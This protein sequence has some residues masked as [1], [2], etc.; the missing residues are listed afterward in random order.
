MI[1]VSST[2]PIDRRNW[3]ATIGLALLFAVLVLVPVGAVRAQS[4]DSIVWDRY[5]VTLDVQSDGTVQV[6]EY[7]EITFYGEYSQGFAY[8]P[9]TQIEDIEDVTVSVANQVGD[10]PQPLE[11]VR[12]SLYDADTGTYTYGIMSGELAI[13]YAF[14]PTSWSGSTTRVVVLEYVV[15]ANQ[16]E[17]LPGRGERLREETLHD[18]VIALSACR[19]LRL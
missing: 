16:V 5:D 19:N 12:S 9:L 15:E 4:A 17:A 8:I 10:T 14:D 2:S 13:D 1:R 7:Q 6:T 11:Y 18:L 3:L